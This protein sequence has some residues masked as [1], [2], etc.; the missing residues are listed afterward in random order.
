MQARAA[1][2][3]FAELPPQAREAAAYGF[4]AR[5]ALPLTGSRSLSDYLAKSFAEKSADLERRDRLSEHPQ[6]LSLAPGSLLAAFHGGAG[7]GS[8]AAEGE[9]PEDG[10]NGQ[11]GSVS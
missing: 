3:R 1:S 4:A 11:G 8:E 5:L 9:G 7:S 6:P 2:V 10:A